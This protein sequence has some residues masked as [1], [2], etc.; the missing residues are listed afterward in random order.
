LTN[1]MM[2]DSSAFSERLRAHRARV[3]VEIGLEEP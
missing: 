3:G 2:R 1:A